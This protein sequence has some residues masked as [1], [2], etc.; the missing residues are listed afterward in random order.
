LNN[1]DFTR[2]LSLRAV[3]YI[4]FILYPIVLVLITFA[5][6]GLSLWLGEKFS[7]NSSL[8]LQ[9][10]AAGILFNGIA[11]IP[12]A[13]LDGIGRPDITAKVQLIELPFYLLAMWF[14]IKNKGI[15]GAAFVWMLRMIVDA[16]LLFF[17]AKRQISAHFEFKFKL[18]YLFIFLLLF[19]SFC[20]V[21]I[22]STSLK[23]VL[24][25]MT[26]TMFLYSSWKFLL[27]GEEKM[28]LISRIKIFNK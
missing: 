15:N 16:F 24:V 19:I 6:E 3:K 14:A 20:L 21:L 12:Y 13:F 10:L 11:Y 7:T 28:F 2:K 1:P 22:S 8:I 26:L 4:F 25:L 27:V 17:F 9:F 5:N 18:N 23:F